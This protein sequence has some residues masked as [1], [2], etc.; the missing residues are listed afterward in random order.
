MPLLSWLVVPKVLALVRSAWNVGLSETVFTIRGIYYATTNSYLFTADKI[1]RFSGPNRRMVFHNGIQKMSLF[2]I[3]M[4][5]PLL[6]M[7][8]CS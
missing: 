6:F 3:Q 4:S 2:A 8:G 5:W 1:Y 7:S